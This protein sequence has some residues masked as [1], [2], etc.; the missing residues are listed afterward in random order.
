M[1]ARHTFKT[2]AGDTVSHEFHANDLNDALRQA[3]LFV[4]LINESHTIVDY[5]ERRI[6]QTLSVSAA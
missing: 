3:G 4:R 2:A 5:P 6:V 1:N